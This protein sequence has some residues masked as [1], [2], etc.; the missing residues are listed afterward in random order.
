MPPS[1][2]KKQSPGDMHLQEK[3]NFSS[4]YSHWGNKLLLKYASCTAAVDGQRKETQGH[5]A[6]SLSYNVISGPF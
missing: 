4:N 3:T 2:K 1:L 5:I 6:V